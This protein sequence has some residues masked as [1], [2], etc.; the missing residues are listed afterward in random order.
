M[1]PLSG[2]RVLIGRARGQA[3]VLAA[4]LRQ[5]GAQVV[6]VPFIAIRPPRSYR[7]LDA[8][9][10]DLAAC[11]WL[12]LTS[13]NGVHALFTRLKRLHLK[14]SALARLRIAAI[15]PAT[16]A[17]I[18]K[19]GIKVA[20]MPAEYV[21]ESVVASLKKKVRGQRVLL[22]RARVARDV[23]PRELRRV[24]ARVD[25]IEAYRTE[26]PAASRRI[27]AAIFSAP[28]RR[29]DVVTFTSSSTVRNFVK[30]VGAARARAMAKSGVCFA[31]IGPVTSATLRQL[32]LPVHI[33]A[34]EYTMPGL[35]R[36]IATQYAR[37]RRGA[38]SA[39]P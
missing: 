20:A 12:I 7:P 15:G 5:Q 34:R 24:G 11:D 29:P 27:L 13:V 16:R 25:V 23:I 33:E 35:V 14:K 22:V 38:A 28:A 18:E 2:V 21:A 32:G 9:L 3:P 17:A 19:Q 31:S 4:A 26:L 37:F 39:A 6:S 36:A 30:L 8:A 1:K 10:R